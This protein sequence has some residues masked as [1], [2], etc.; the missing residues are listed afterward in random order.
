MI[1]DLKDLQKLFKL[2]RAQGITDF[3]MGEIEIK[4]GELPT[5]G[6]DIQ[7]VEMGSS[8]ANFP[9]GELTPDQLMFYSSGGLPEEDPQNKEA[10]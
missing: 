7:E 6:Q 3:K 2:C 10:I 4:F 9:K 8:Y 5:E 1:S